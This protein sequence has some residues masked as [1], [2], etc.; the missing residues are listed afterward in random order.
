M[1]QILQRHRADLVALVFGLLFTAIGS[2]SLAHELDAFEVE[3]RGFLGITLAVVGAVGA[4]VVLVAAFR[5]T[6]HDHSPAPSTLSD[7]TDLLEMSDLTDLPDLAEI[8]ARPDPPRS[9]DDD[10][11][12]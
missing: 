2:L 6:P 7:P 4:I 9:G 1:S 5:R 8:A 11:A 10:D 3:G 12:L